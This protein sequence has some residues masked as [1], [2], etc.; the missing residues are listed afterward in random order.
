MKKIQYIHLSKISTKQRSAKKGLMNSNIINSHFETLSTNSLQILLSFLEPK[1]QILSL[2]VC[3]KFKIAFAD[4]NSFDYSHLTVFNRLLNF[5]FKIEKFSN[6]YSPYLN[7]YLNV[8]LLNISPLNFTSINLNSENELTIR[9]KAF[10]YFLTYRQT[11]TNNNKIYISIPPHDEQCIKTYIQFFQTYKHLSDLKSTI[12]IKKGFV[13]NNESIEMMIKL[14]TLIPNLEKVESNFTK[15]CLNAIQQEIFKQNI[16]CV[17]L[18]LFSMKE[19]DV[20]KAVEYFKQ[21]NNCLKEITNKN[22]KVLCAYN[23]E[24]IVSIKSGSPFEI[25][26]ITPMLTNLIEIKFN[27]ASDTFNN[28]FNSNTFASVSN[29]IKCIGGFTIENEN[30]CDNIISFINSKLPSL[31]ALHYITFGNE[32]EDVDMQVLFQ[33]LCSKLQTTSQIEQLNIWGYKLKKQKDYSYCLDKL[34]NLRK[35]WEDYDVSSWYD[36]RFE[37]EDVFSCNTERQLINNDLEVLVNI[38]SNYLNKKEKGE[39]Y[40]DIRLYCD[41]FTVGN[42]CKYCVDN[43]KQWIIDAIGSVDY[44]VDASSNYIDKYV[45]LSHLNWFEIKREN[46]MMFKCVKDIKVDVLF[47]EDSSILKEDIIELMKSMK[48]HCIIF[49]RKLNDD[50]KE[51]EQIKSIGNSVKIVALI[52]KEEC[53]K[54]KQCYKDLDFLVIENH[55][56]MEI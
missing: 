56:N 32:D 43:N 14:Y 54:V 8:N 45:G 48:P 53:D 11:R 37:I 36:V 38:I 23:K 24:S 7:V 51:I 18:N 10:Q 49:K 17:H 16:K 46:Q 4:T 19:S 47:V 30:D 42:L 35:I 1:E 26:D 44:I 2:S 40:I 52:N 29:S 31:N 27:Y 9:N 34:P 3:S 13:L 50:V 33:Y 15:Q 5:Y 41:E 22:Q 12:Y 21:H 28:Y 20:L 39:K 25:N 55:I 6:N